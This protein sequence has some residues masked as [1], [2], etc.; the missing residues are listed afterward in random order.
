MKRLTQFMLSLFLCSLLAACDTLPS[1]N[2]PLSSDNTGDIVA[3]AADTPQQ[4]VENFLNAWQQEEFAIMH[5]LLHP[6]SIE[7]YPVDAFVDLYTDT[8][9]DIGFTGVAYTINEVQLQGDS[10]AIL[11]DVEL[12]TAT[13]GQIIDAERTMRLVD[14]NG[15]WKIAW[16]P[17]DIINGMTANVR[18]DPSRIFPPRGNIYDA[19]GQLL[20][21]QNGT[22]YGVIMRLS[23]MLNEDECTALLSRV[24]LRPISYFNALYIDYRAGDTAFFVGE[25]DSEIYERNRGELE[26][27]CAT[28]IDV[29]LI[30]S[31]IRPR[32]G[33]TYFGHGAAAHI[34]GYVGFVSDVEYW[35]GR[36]YSD[37]DLVGSAG[38]EFT[39]Q[40]QLAGV[41]EQSLRL[42][43]SS[44]VTLR[45]LGTATGTSSTSVTLTIDRELQWHTAEAFIDAWNYAG[46]NWATRATGGAAVVMD[47]NTGAIL[48]MF[49]FPT[50][51][52]AIFFPDSN[53]WS[54]S[55]EYAGAS[56]QIQRATSN[57]RFLPVGPATINRAYTEQYAPGS[58]FKIMSTLAAADSGTW[59][60]DQLFN[61]ELTWD[62][63]SYGD[64]GGIREDWRVV[65]GRDAAGEITMST[66]LTTSC[67]PFFWQVGSLM[68]QERPNLLVNYLRNWGFGEPTRMIGLSIEAEAPGIIP[69]PDDVTVAINNVIG[70]GD[71]Q[72]TAVQ[73]VRLVAAV[74]NGG[75]LYEPYLVQEVGTGSDNPQTIQPVVEGQLDVS[76]TAL[77]VTIA[78]MCQVPINIEF[79][80]STSSFGDSR[81]PPSYT[82]CGKTGT[83]QTLDAPNS[84]YV[85]YAPADNPQIAVA[86][87]VPNSRE[88]SEVSAPLV[89]RILDHYFNGPIA[90]YPIWWEGE[91]V[92]VAV[93]QG[94]G[95]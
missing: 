95:G 17:M 93:P 21:N 74:A 19:N 53:Y 85:A 83:A 44:G 38:V 32:V 61:C 10:A 23:D 5:N 41:P 33:R 3:Q 34:T 67:N 18:L 25:I 64:T 82:S 12:D 81:T 14:D 59:G 39:Y 52:P 71:T 76:E 22:T 90:E 80:T 31:K 7:I 1:L 66:A 40:D 26:R 73:M 29:E 6:R 89:R 8:H 45:E 78:G 49:S 9:A 28:N 70:Q 62:G 54:T 50:Y 30:G 55:T 51:D 84:W 91:Y 27:L 75:T 4:T 65:E 58:V 68:Y 56:A 92:P 87:V 43:D 16:S 63:S 2:N 13:F 24:M 47:V 20:V 11:Y 72:V 46:I 15:I 36:G 42:I 86:V 57:G 60:Q 35:R 79:G 37:T 48:S 94:V 69:Q 77:Q 88:G